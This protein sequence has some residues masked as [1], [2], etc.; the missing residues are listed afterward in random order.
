MITTKVKREY[1]SIVEKRLI[2]FYGYEPKTALNAVDRLRH[3]MESIDTIG[4]VVYH[5]D[6]KE[7]ADDIA[8]M[9]R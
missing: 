1:W 6:P 3:D 8:S 9:G 4:D 2:N 7:V 5:S